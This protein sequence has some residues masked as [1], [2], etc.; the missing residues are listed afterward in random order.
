MSNVK[1]NI[2]SRPADKINLGLL[3]AIG[4][5]LIT[6]IVLVEHKLEPR[7]LSTRL[8]KISRLLGMVTNTQKRKMLVNT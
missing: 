4:D 7:D 1:L 5:L 8:E 2:K 6:L 3:R